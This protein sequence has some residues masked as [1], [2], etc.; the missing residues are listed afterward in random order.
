MEILENSKICYKCGTI[1]GLDNFYKN[2]TK[3]D[4]FSNLCKEC[5]KVYKNDYNQ[6]NKDKISIY[7]TKY[8]IENAEFIKLYKKNI[9]REIKIYNRK[10]K[11]ARIETD[12]NFKLAC[13]L[14]TR[15]CNAI[16]QKQKIGSAILDLGCSID[17]FKSYIEQQ[18]QL[19]MSWNNY[20]EWHLDHILPLSSFD[21]TNREQFLKACH[22]T[23]HQ[24]LW[25][26][27]N[28]KK[29]NKVMGLLK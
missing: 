18:F 2:K 24:P 29:N 13:R 12:L 8:R 1:K 16:A 7:N 6:K 22:Y 19:G 23:N 17:F 11:K 25:A 27:D 14:R 3:K 28:F 21:L 15:L 20:G 26:E 4:G 5:S 9:R 10:Y